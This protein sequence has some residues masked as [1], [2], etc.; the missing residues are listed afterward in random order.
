MPRSRCVGALVAAAIALF[1]TTTTTVR[2]QQAAIEPTAA[3]TKDATTSAIVAAT[4][5]SSVPIG[6]L[7]SSCDG[8][9][10]TYQA[11]IAPAATS[12]GC[13]CITMSGTAPLG[14]KGYALLIPFDSATNASLNNAKL[15]LFET[16]SG[17]WALGY[18]AY[19][20][21]SEVSKITSLDIPPTATS[22]YVSL[23]PD[24]PT[25]YSYLSIERSAVLTLATRA[26]TSTGHC[27]AA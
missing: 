26:L 22:V 7:T 2:A 12:T 27:E 5:C 18:H 20:S 23:C 25:S 1:S 21:N 15:P 24:L 16:L 3:G 10:T 17:K 8:A 13:R 19:V 6:T 9:C 11:C 4:S 14:Y